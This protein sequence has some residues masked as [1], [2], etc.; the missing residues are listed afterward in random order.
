LDLWE[1]HLTRNRYWE[2][3][4]G[5]GDGAGGEE[6]RVSYVVTPAAEWFR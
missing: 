4:Y 6:A 1:A 3:K 2:E 5:G